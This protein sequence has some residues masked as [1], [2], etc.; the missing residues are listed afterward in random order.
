MVMKRFVHISIITLI[1]ILSSIATLNYFIDP[2]WC[3]NHSY[4]FNQYQKGSNE[5]QQKTNQ[6]Y[7]SNKKYDSLLLGSSRVTYFNKKDLKG[8]VFNYS[9]SDMQPKEYKSFVDFAINNAKQDIKTIYLGLDF[10]GSLAYGIKKFNNPKQYAEATLSKFYRY[11]V[12]LSIDALNNSMHNLK[13]FKKMGLDTYNRDNLKSPPRLFGSTTNKEV[14]NVQEY[15]RYKYHP[16]NQDPNFKNYLLELKKS[17]PKINFI[18]FSTPVSSAL[19]DEITKLQLYDSYEAW[20]RDITSVFGEINH[21]M[22]KNS[23]SSQNQ[24]F[25]D[26]NHAYPLY[27]KQI[28]EVLNSSNYNQI[29]IMK[30]NQ[31]NIEEM[32]K[33]LKIKNTQVDIDRLSDKITL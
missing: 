3:F 15:S 11:K 7:F 24:Y 29:I 31:N 1:F 27:Y 22:F 13:K 33:K 6:L 18:V 25:M 19:I 8:E 21:F 26:S 9:C 32:L 30:I 2:Y 4:S 14:F 16:K 5:R 10:Y 28:A 23:L 12:L 20:L 17:Y